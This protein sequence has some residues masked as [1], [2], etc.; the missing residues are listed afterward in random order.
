MTHAPRSSS[1]ARPSWVLRFLFL[2]VVL[3]TLSVAG[4][5]GLFQ[6]DLPE[7]AATWKA[8]A[9]GTLLVGAAEADITPTNHQYMGGYNIARMSTGVFSPL[10]A[11]AMVLIMG[12]Q[13]FAIVGYDNLGMQREDVDWV[14]RG[15]KGFANGNVLLCASH[16]H[17]GPDLVG[18]WGFYF[19]TS[20]R[21]PD[22]L[23]L[24][25]EGVS[26]AVKDA[27]ARAR[28][29]RLVHGVAR[30]PD[31]ILRNSNRKGL[32]NRRFTVIQARDKETD[33]PLGTLLHLACHPEIFRRENTLISADYPGSLCDAWAAAGLGQAVFVNGELGAMI[34]P[35]FKP[36]GAKGI[37]LIGNRLMV[38]GRAALT[39]AKE[40]VVDEIELRRRDLY[41]PLE[42]PGLKFARLTMVI[43][44]ELYDGHLRS[45]VSYLRLGSFEAACVPGEMEPGLAARIRAATHRPDLVIFGLVDDEVGYLL[46]EKDAH[47]PLFLYERTVSP[48]VGAGE[49]V[50]NALV[51][52][53]RASP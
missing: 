47:D 49:M 30:L 26:R 33:K 5:A 40:L 50:S 3:A 10:K 7:T 52:T 48:G 24:V 34:T 4:C 15:I 12:D 22:Y 9:S 6:R 35:R 42:S 20:G 53:V 28:P 25:R 39:G 46:A 37:P 32:Y 41:F 16:T 21:D 18:M 38:L 13:R 36:K 45:S 31:G 1:P 23:A 14:K 19:L 27:V 51:G 2:A 17:A 8:H 44:R 11:R 43:P 29:A